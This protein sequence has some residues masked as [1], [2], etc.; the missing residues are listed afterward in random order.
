VENKGQK[1]QSTTLDSNEPRLVLF[2][3]LSS[4]CNQEMTQEEILNVV[5]S[6][7]EGSIL[8]QKVIDWKLRNNVDWRNAY[9]A[10]GL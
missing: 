5:N 2:I 8:E 7:I 9:I 4:N 3:K 6:Y 10:T 1:G